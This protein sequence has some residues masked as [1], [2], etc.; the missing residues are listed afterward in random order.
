MRHIGY[1]EKLQF[2]KLENEKSIYQFLY[3]YT[4]MALDLGVK[5]W[6]IN[7][8]S[9]KQVYKEYSPFSTNCY[10][11]GPFMVHV[12][13][14]LRFDERFPLKEDY[15]FTLQNLNKYRKVLR[16]NKYCYDVKQKEQTG[17]VADYRTLEEERRQLLL[18]QKKWGSDIIKEDK[19][20]SGKGK[21]SN[22]IRTYDI[23]PRLIS[24]IKGV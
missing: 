21:Q 17:G 8:N 24:P 20:K 3:K 11:G 1:W 15:D 14:D 19:I 22:K 10:I 16:I 4:I 13:T 23:N 5:L 6:G 9:D 7:V 2:H 12:D 18:L